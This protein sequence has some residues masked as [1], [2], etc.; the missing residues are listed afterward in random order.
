MDKQE[1]YSF[2]TLDFVIGCEGQGNHEIVVRIDQHSS[3]Y[4]QF[5]S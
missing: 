1:V 4:V 2:N 3:M 5:Y